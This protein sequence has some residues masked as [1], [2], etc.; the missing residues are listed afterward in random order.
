[1]SFSKDE[2]RNVV[3]DAAY[4]N[5]QAL[6]T[7]TYGN[8]GSSEDEFTSSARDRDGADD[9]FFIFRAMKEYCDKNSLFML[10]KMEL[11]HLIQFL[12]S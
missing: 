6:V 4:D 3:H 1:M 7:G 12:R 8:G 9:S 2:Y 11:G 10:E 5:E